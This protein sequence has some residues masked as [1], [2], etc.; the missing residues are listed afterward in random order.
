VRKLATGTILLATTAQAAWAQTPGGPRQSLLD[1]FIQ[2][3]EIP[4]YFIVLGSVV[5]ITLII[6]HFLTVR[7]ANIAPTP[8]IKRA[9]QQIE[10][11]DF[12]EC[13]ATLKKS[14]SFFAQVMGTAL[15]HARHGFDAMHE[16]ALERSNQ[17]SA[18]MYRKAEYLNIIGNLGP[19]LG[20]LGTVWGMIK[21]FGALGAG[22]GQAGA[23]DL[24]GGISMALVNTA[25]G[26]ALAILGIGFFGFCRN[27]IESLTVAATVE[28][29]DLLE[30]FRPASTRLTPTSPA[31]AASSQ[32][33]DTA[34]EVSA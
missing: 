8:Q 1:I 6:E 3:V 25:A 2:G 16:A 23:G 7:I 17:L 30:Y 21:A 24:A 19:L 20:L 12:R 28:V 31:P 26:L 29:L 10:A 33:R 32:P 22:G 18:R 15:Q 14:Q 34:R 27:R 4:T 9:K 5:V 11:R 13:L